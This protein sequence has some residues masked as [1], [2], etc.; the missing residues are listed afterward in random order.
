MVFG[1]HYGSGGGGGHDRLNGVSNI[2]VKQKVTMAE[3]V[4]PMCEQS[5]IYETFDAHT[6]QGLFLV[7]E[8]SGCCCRVFCNPA[9]KLNLKFFPM[10]GGGQ[11][12]KARKES[13]NAEMQV[14]RP[15]KCA[16]PCPALMGF[17]QQE[18]TMYHGAYEEEER[19][20][21]ANRLGS[22]K[23]PCLGGCL[24]PKM[25]VQNAAGGEL[26]VVKGPSCCFGGLTECCCDQE[27]N[28]DFAD[29]QS[30]R[31]VRQRPEDLKGAATTL[32]TDS[33]TFAL[34]LPAEMAAQ[35]K[36]AMLGTLLLLDYMFFEQ[37]RP[38]ECADGGLKFTCCY[39]YLCGAVVP[40]KV[41]C[42]GKKD[43]DSS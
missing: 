35:D 10:S 14:F 34:E 30:G 15:F 39:W 33:D 31:I 25:E 32:F 17:C 2:I 4:C 28:V 22:A 21:P 11:G 8:D 18:M 29:G 42:G 1:F 40:C 26:A 6:G 37:D 38:W 5:N 23:E 13:E 36:A 12:Q 24:A 7:E 19:A 3:A 27:F 16:G 20:D 9:H 43:D 41:K